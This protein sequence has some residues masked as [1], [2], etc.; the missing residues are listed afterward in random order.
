[1]LLT[2]ILC[3]EFLLF[4]FSHIYVIFVLSVSVTQQSIACGALWMN[5]WPGSPGHIPRIPYVR[6]AAALWD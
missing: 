2:Y 1:M 4:V 5:V 6:W 3:S